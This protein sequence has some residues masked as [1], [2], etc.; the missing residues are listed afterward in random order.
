MPAGR[1]S[2]LRK[3]SP[4]EV[5]LDPALRTRLDALLFSPV[6]KRIPKGAYQRF[7]NQV[8]VQTLNWTELDLSPYAGTFP[9]EAIVR[10]PEFAIEHLKRILHAP[11]PSS[12]NC[13]L[14]PESP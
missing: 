3:T 10:G 7:F 2:L 4:L 14:A 9:T 5:S 12:E 1:P 11:R 8:L 13:P 6:E